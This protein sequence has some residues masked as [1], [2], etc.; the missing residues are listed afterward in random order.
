[1]EL[2]VL[3]L[4]DAATDD[5]GKLNIL[6]VFDSLQAPQAPFKHP[7]CAVALRIRFHLAEEGEHRLR[8]SLI[9]ED[10]HAA[11]PPIDATVTVRIDPALGSAAL[12]L[13]VNIQ[14]LEVRRFGEHRLDLAM[15]EKPLGSLPFFVRQVPA[16]V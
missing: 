15:D 7:A 8:L 2:E 16:P 14:R 13:I 12:N 5:R 1:M 10:G 3:A 4:C 11:A 6:G 9:D